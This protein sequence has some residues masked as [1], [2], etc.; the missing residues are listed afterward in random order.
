MQVLHAGWREG[1]EVACENAL[2]R[3]DVGAF[4]QI[5]QNARPEGMVWDRR[6]MNRIS[7]FT[8]LRLG[9]ELL[10]EGNWAEFV[11]FVRR[12]HVGLVSPPVALLQPFRIDL[13][14]PFL[15]N[16]TRPNGV[17][18]HEQCSERR[19]YCTCWTCVVPSVRCLQSRS[20]TRTKKIT[21]TSSAV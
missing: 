16:A 19:M 2:P 10:E 21:V 13:Q 14:L 6:P 4:N 11:R 12:M 1:L 18:C 8:F 17:P 9:Q 7:S 20:G 3:Y 15:P 5:I